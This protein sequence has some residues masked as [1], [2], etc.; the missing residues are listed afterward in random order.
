[1]RPLFLVLPL[2]LATPALAAE[3]PS[4]DC[5]K[6]RSAQERLVCAD[7]GL[8]ALDRQ[9]AQV[10]SALKVA[11]PANAPDLVRGQAAWLR[12]RDAVQCTGNKR[13]AS[14]M[15]LKRAYSE[16]I[17]LLKA[18]EFLVCGRPKMSGLRFSVTCDALNDPLRLAFVL[19]GTSDGEKT[20]GRATLKTLAAKAGARTQTLA[21][22]GDV[23]MDGVSGAV[24]LMDVNFDGFDDIKL[25]TATSAGPNSGYSYWLYDPKT[26]GFKASD[27]GDKLSGFDIDLDP[28][29]KTV[30]AGGRAS[31]CLWEGTTYRWVRSELRVVAIDMTGML[32]LSRIPGLVMDGD[33]QVCG[34]ETDRYD[35]AENLVTTELAIEGCE[36]DDG[37]TES[38][39]ADILSALERHPKGFTLRIKDQQHFTVVY[40]KPLPGLNTP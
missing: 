13:V 33:A 39:P 2:F 1:M 26:A 30:R 27:I 23:W 29:A 25:W 3:T 22:E 17:A 18:K 6:A 24:E 10:F 8:A 28:K 38:K 14:A 15:C 4:F 37:K 31:C 36:D 19:S 9:M 21:V 11:H 7:A 40:D 12:D 5:G 16:R 32:S 20:A 34:T 35:A